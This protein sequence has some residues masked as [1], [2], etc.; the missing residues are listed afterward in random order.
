[1]DFR[2]QP[3]ETEFNSSI[4]TLRR[5]DD[6]MRQLHDLSRGIIPTNKFGIPLI[7][8]NPYELYITTTERLYLEGQNKFKP[9]EKKR[10][11]ELCNETEKIRQ[12]YGNNLHMQKISKGMPPHEYT[13]MEYYN[14]W[15]ELLKANKEYEL[16][17][18]ECLDKHGMLLINKDTRLAASK[19]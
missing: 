16:F 3:K 18:V 1:M 4:A 8:G 19:V 11:N 10:A 12:K 15:N 7:T 5:I 17:V 14:G 2:D 9:E 13:N 6:L